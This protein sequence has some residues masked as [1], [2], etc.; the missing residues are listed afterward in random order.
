MMTEMKPSGIDGF[1]DI[2]VNWEVNKMAYVF[3]FGKGLSITKEDLQ[4][5]GIPA[6]SYG[7]IHSRYGFEVDPAKHE[8]R[9]VDPKYIRTSPSSLLRYGD[10]IFADTSEDI[11][12]SGNFTHLSS[13][14]TTFASYHTIIA[15]AR[16][17]LDCR[18]M[19]YLFDSEPFRTQIRHSVSGVKVFSIT[20]MILKNAKLLLPPTTEQHTIATF[21]DD[22]CGQVDSIIADSERQVEILR[23]YKKALITETVTKGLDKSAPMKDSGIDWIG[24]MPSHWE[25]KRLKFCLSSQL[26]YGANESGD[27]FD[28]KYPRYIRITDIDS[29]NSLKEDGKLSLFP[30]VAKPYLL[31]DGDVLFARSGATVGKS[32]FYESKYGTAA[33]AGYLI[34]ARTNKRI[35]LPKFLYYI[36][37]GSG[38]EIWKDR[39]FSQATIQNIGADKYSQLFLT[40]GKVTEQLEIIDFLDAKCTEA[41]ALIAEK[42]KA[43]EVMRQYKKSLIYEYVTGKKRVSS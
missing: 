6:V 3:S 22:R 18:Y 24:E 21:L 14:E 34:K 29:D 5:E 8:L 39:V 17:P 26:Q 35:L 20:Q 43:I 25:I 32:F 19:A 1:F 10:F 38:Y 4:D 42:Q 41:D 15:R 27:E 2:P 36:T 37:L 16:Q 11:A 12:G 30:T 33:F 28:E 9:C 7:D 13:H 31:S 23:Q 40:I